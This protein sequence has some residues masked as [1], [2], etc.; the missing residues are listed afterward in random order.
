M[1]DAKPQEANNREQELGVELQELNDTTNNMKTKK[2][3]EE[4][5]RS[6]TKSKKQRDRSEAKFKRQREDFERHKAT[7]EK[8]F[9]AVY[10][11]LNQIHGNPCER[12]LV[13][14][15]YSTTGAHIHGDLGRLPPTENDKA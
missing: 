13:L 5:S 12:E 7:F 15:A 11:Q 8:S 1:L 3:E 10:D 2:L 4:R 14:G 9:K 6:D